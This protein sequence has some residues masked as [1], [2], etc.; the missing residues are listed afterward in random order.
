MPCTNKMRKDILYKIIF[1]L[2]F[3]NQNLEILKIDND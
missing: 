2:S 1:S 3:N